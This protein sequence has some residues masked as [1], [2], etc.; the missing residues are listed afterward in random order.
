MLEIENLS[1][2]WRPGQVLLDIPKMCLG[3]SERL[4]L[5]GPSGSGK[6]SLLG[7]IG[8]M[9]LPQRGSI[10]IL[11]TPIESLKG[12]ARDRFRADHIG[13]IFQ[14]FNLLPYLDA[15]DNV[16][17]ALEFSPRRRARLGTVS[18]R[19]EAL[20]LLQRLHLDASSLDGRAA[21][22]LS[23]GQQ[24]RVAAAR[25]LIGAPELVIADE[26]TSALDQDTRENFLAL[27][28]DECQR[29][30]A[31]LLFVSH[32]RSLEARFDRSVDLRALN[33]ADAVAAC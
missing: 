7:L 28:F 18:A 19:A 29:A 32:D 23:V 24:Q 2:G 10:R 16:L 17:L 30:G 27:L 15:V 9:L 31:A 14:Q 21:A 3:Q 1:F 4:F 8:G 13:L 25:A 20:S 12:A 26:P 11:D 5:R 33:R 6:S 22:Q